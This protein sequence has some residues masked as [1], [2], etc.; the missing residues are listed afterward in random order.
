MREQG[1]KGGASHTGKLIRPNICTKNGVYLNELHGSD[2]S[3]F[4]HSS[5]SSDSQH[6]YH[7]NL[8]Q[9]W[10]PMAYVSSKVPLID[11][12]HRREWRV[13][14]KAHTAASAP[15]WYAR[16]YSYS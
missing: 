4:R 11:A 14:V 6:H 13:S 16:Q 9:I 8:T 5:Y 12:A 10:C 3:P 15:C 2:T 1:L 7:D